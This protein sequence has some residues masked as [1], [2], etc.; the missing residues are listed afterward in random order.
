MIDSSLTYPPVWV[1][2]DYTMDRIMVTHESLMG[3][4]W[5]LHSY[6]PA[7][8]GDSTGKIPGLGALATGRPVFGIDRQISQI[9]QPYTA[10]DAAWE[11][12]IPRP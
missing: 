3:L 8:N 11:W 10:F 1:G 9:E 5:I 7:G 2:G 6:I 12:G 4:L